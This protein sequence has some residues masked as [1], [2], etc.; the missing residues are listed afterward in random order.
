MTVRSQLSGS[1]PGSF[2]F[3][4]L[5]RDI[6]M[7]IKFVQ[8]L[9]AFLLLAPVLTPAD[10]PQPLTV[11]PSLPLTASPSAGPVE[12][13]LNLQS[14]RKWRTG[15][16]AI[17]ASASTEVV[18][19]KLKS[20]RG[21]PA[22]PV[23]I[24]P[25]APGSM[26]L[27]FDA[28]GE[29][30][31]TL[32]GSV[33]TP[34]GKLSEVT[35]VGVIV[36]AGKVWLAEGGI[37]AALAAK[38]RAE[39][40]AALPGADAA[41]VD[42]AFRAKLTEVNQLRQEKMK[43]RSR[44]SRSPR[45][46]AADFNAGD[47]LH[48]KGQWR[49]P[50]PADA[51]NPVDPATVVTFAN[52]GMHGVKVTA[53]DKSNAALTVSTYLVGGL[54]SFAAP[55]RDFTLKLDLS[56]PGITAGGGINTAGG[57]IGHF[58]AVDLAGDVHTFTIDAPLPLLG[59]T[60]AEAEA[61]PFLADGTAARGGETFGLALAAF[62][63][64]EDMVEETLTA[65]AVN[66]AGGFRLRF[67]HPGGTSTFSSA[68]NRLNITRIRAYVWD[69]IGHEFGHMVQ[70]DTG[71]INAAG[72]AHD[73]SNQ[74]SYVGPPANAGTLN[75]KL[76][77]NRLALNEG[78][79]TWIGV[80]FTE[81][82]SRYKGKIKWVG[83][84]K[85]R[86]VFNTEVNDTGFKGEDTEDAIGQLLWDLHDANNE[87][88][89]ATGLKDSTS[90]TLKTLYQL[91]VG[92]AMN[93]IFNVWEEVAG[94][95]LAD[96][97]AVSGIPA[98]RLKKAL[99][100]AITFAEFGIA[101]HLQAPA[102]GSKIDLTAM[103]G[104][105]I[106]WRQLASGHAD[107][108]LN[109]FTIL[110]YAN[111]YTGVLWSK[112]PPVVAG[113]AQE[114]DLVKADLDAIKAATTGKNMA[115]VI[116]V[117]SG[118]ADKVA[119]AT[120]PYLSNGVEVLLQDYN[121][122]AVM[123]V[124]SS[125]SNTS[126]DPT[127][128]RVAA[129]KATLANL[130]SLAEAVPP[131]ILVPDIAAGVT[132]TT[133]SSILSGW[134]D[135]DAVIPAM[136]GVFQSGGTSI[137]SGIN[138]GIG[139]LDSINNTGFIAF[140]QNKAA[141]VVLTDGENNSGPGPVI[142]AIAAAT[143]KGIRTH[144]GFLS[145][146]FSPAPPPVRAP[147]G[148]PVLPATIEDAVRQSGG[149]FARIGDAQSQVA[150]I[151]QIFANGLTNN[152][153]L[154]PGGL[155]VVGQT[156]T[157][158]GLANADDMR[159]FRFHGAGGENIS[160]RVDTGG[161][162]QPFVTLFDATGNI[163]AVGDDSD[164][165]GIVEFSVVLPAD[166]EYTVEVYSDDGRF[167]RFTV[168]IDVANITDHIVA[169]PPALDLQTGL[170]R[171]TVTINVPAAGTG[172]RLLVNGLAAGITLY[173]MS[174][175]TDTGTPY[176]QWDQPVTAGQVITLVLEYFSP[177]LGVPAPSLSLAAPEAT[178]VPPAIVPFMID[179]ATVLPGGEV[180]LEF[181]SDPG[182]RY[183]IQYNDDNT[184]WKSTGAPITAGGNRVQWRDAGPPKTSPHPSAVP[185]RFYRAAKI[186]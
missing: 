184:T 119:P 83:D 91:F 36:S 180:L 126:T 145:P 15:S 72:G 40:Q 182:G 86:D 128:Q 2:A 34:H 73:G 129:A 158:D 174:G 92:K 6:R 148:A 186:N 44:P 25:A 54:C 162:F 38:T 179:K 115:S 58:T 99:G 130:V 136:D 165:D 185:S 100:A 84:K 118:S 18:D 74:Y 49:A 155:S 24:S 1:D 141:I 169:A 113:R 139:L 123:V 168:F 21:L 79:G 176:I 11:V 82:S 171:Q 31:L 75:N 32:A 62:H 156:T 67:P 81:R 77:A 147:R 78:Y 94:K 103:S 5:N 48:F 7:K 51:G 71:A 14:S 137:D 70:N 57:G 27:Q 22:A 102:A 177:A 3:S 122:A 108:D 181:P 20:V 138:T 120:G 63:G 143:A 50:A 55:S 68:D 107:M 105:K 151:Q 96:L 76:A 46:A 23:A 43:E 30:L 12:I 110:L 47:T 133:S 65:L 127:R 111:D 95:P 29:F 85:Y 144:Y 167:G 146:F 124:D 56:F 26:A 152:D 28:D 93:S 39:V 90:L 153:R 114:Y 61:A 64:V 60:V 89:A 19:S 173:N 183:L 109:K 13:K 41:S 88:Y 10:E 172:F 37:E 80:A 16:V 125:G 87:A 132:F 140:I 69:V 42:A 131:S 135:P 45:V 154:D 35:I 157:T 170:Y 161:T 116:L 166:A 97:T 17:T 159:A 142:A 117:I 150:F 66:K 52:F 33:E 104:P 101:P 9:L 134:A 59:K 106:K 4:Q 53:T 164:G 121:R 178:P 175:A 149:I 98:A 8:T 112:V 160:I 163:L